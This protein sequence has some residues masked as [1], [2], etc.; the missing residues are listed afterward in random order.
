MNLLRRWGPGALEVNALVIRDLKIIAGSPVYVYLFLDGLS[1]NSALENLVLGLIEDFRK[2][3]VT[4][5][6]DVPVMDP[7]EVEHVHLDEDVLSIPG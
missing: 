6:D 1:R 3:M 5:S 4:G 7:L 2:T